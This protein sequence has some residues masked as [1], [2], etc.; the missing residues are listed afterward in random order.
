MRNSPFVNLLA[1]LGLATGGLV[2][3]A[4]TR[5]ME[6]VPPPP[7]EF[8]TAASPDPAELPASTER[9]EPIAPEDQVMFAFDSAT[10]ASGSSAVLDDVAAWVQGDPT[11]TILVRGQA[12]ASGT[13]AYNFDLSARRAEAVADYLVSKGVNRQQISITAT[14][15]Q[16][17]IIEPPGGNRRVVVFGM[18]S[19]SPES[20]AAR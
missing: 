7:P 20:S 3:C 19:E 16:A 18:T 2:A 5:P 12:D 1:A 10:L 8:E 17:A 9:V 4:E 15:E 13:A 14:G 6:T 11:R